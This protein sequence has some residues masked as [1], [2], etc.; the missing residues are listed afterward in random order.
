MGTALVL[1]L[2]SCK[3]VVLIEKHR[4]PLTTDKI[5]FSFK[6]LCLLIHSLVYGFYYI[7]KQILGHPWKKRVILSLTV[8]D[9][10]TSDNI[11]YHH[12][13]DF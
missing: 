5:G 13:V 8:V 7:F 11:L 12:T 3:W 10:P 4:V 2:V 6:F 1:H 9:N